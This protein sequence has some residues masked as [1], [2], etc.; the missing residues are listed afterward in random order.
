MDTFALFFTNRQYVSHSQWHGTGYPIPPAT[1]MTP[2][3]QQA[4]WQLPSGLL[5]E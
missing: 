2:I 4:G 5:N 1:A 3:T